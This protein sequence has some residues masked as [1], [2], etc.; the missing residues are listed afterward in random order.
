MYYIAQMLLVQREIR[1]GTRMYYSLWKVI[2]FQSVWTALMT[3]LQNSTKKSGLIMSYRWKSLKEH[4]RSNN[5]FF[6]TALNFSILLVHVQ[7]MNNTQGNTE[8]V[9]FETCFLLDL[10]TK[11]TYSIKLCILQR[12]PIV[13]KIVCCATNEGLIAKLDIKSVSIFM[14]FL[15]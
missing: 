13:H 7:F 3:H 12:N 10:K 9:E 1:K 8:L 6:L 2:F 14:D 15:R 5:I 4:F 11:A